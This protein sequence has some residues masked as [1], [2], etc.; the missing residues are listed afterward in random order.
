MRFTTQRSR[1]VRQF[2]PGVGRSKQLRESRLHP[3]R[4]RGQQRAP[5]SSRPQRGPGPQCQSTDAGS[6]AARPQGQ[7]LGFFCLED[8]CTLC[9][10][11]YG[12]QLLLCGRRLQ[13]SGEKT[14]LKEL[15]NQMASFNRAKL[16]CDTTLDHISAQAQTTER[17]IR[18]EEEEEA[19]LV[20]LSQEKK[21]SEVMTS[22][23]PDRIRELEEK[24]AGD[25]DVA[26]LQ[27]YRTTKEKAQNLPPLPDPELALGPGALIDEAKQP[28]QP[29]IEHL[30]EDVGEVVEYFPVILKTKKTLL[31]PLSIRPQT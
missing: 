16:S 7:R 19:R 21:E 13:V 9:D 11:A 2:G 31:L 22:S 12:P 20:A 1:S 24:L 23:L 17:Q 29:S 8:Q 5:E 14:S 18:E 3:G 30:A 28:G 10:G 27:S 26:F 4:S 15:R 25:D 6:M